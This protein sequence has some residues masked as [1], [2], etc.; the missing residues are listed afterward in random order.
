[1]D[2]FLKN[3]KAGEWFPFLGDVRWDQQLH[4]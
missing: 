1:M 4:T 3:N 2:A